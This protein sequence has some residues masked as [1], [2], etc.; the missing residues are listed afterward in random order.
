M[1]RIIA[2]AS[3]VA[4]G[5]ASLH[6]AYAPGLSPQE[7]SKPWSIGLSLRGF[8]DDNP[9]SSPNHPAPG[10]GFSGPEA[11]WG[12]EVSPYVNINM[13]LD[14]TLISFN[15]TYDLRWFENRPSDNNDQY[16]YI[17]LG[18]NHAFS[19][20]YVL[21]VKDSFTVGK[22]P[23]VNF[24]QNGA[25]T[26]LRTEGNYINN[27]ARVGFDAGLSEKFGLNVSYVNNIWDF[28]DTGPSSRS[29]FLDRMEQYPTVEAKY[30]FSPNTVGLIGA[31]FGSVAHTAS[32][33]SNPII[34][35]DASGVFQAYAD[36][37]ARDLW[38][39]YGYVGV[40][41]TFNP[42]LNAAVR[43]GV[44]YASFDNVNDLGYY[45]NYA[46]GFAPNQDDTSTTPYA[47]ASLTWTYNPGCALKVGVMYTRNQ[48]DVASLDQQSAVGYVNLSH[49]LTAKLTASLMG[50]IQNSEYFGGIYDGE[51]DLIYMAGANLNY[52]FNQYLSTDVG[53]NF[54]RDDSDL[55]NRSY[56]RNRFYF[57]LR[58]NY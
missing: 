51:A 29:A 39:L 4:L 43:L 34:I 8:Y 47:D 25:V 1:K 2:S 28:S 10:S 3:M 22:D 58:A 35:S 6:A 57:G 37:D 48:T 44:Q 49:R 32:A 20:R 5:A 21:D 15:Y 11:S 18:I 31:Q 19:E 38:S 13:A 24:D 27:V 30:H 12:I 23:T 42:T 26:F 16:H 53:Y 50:L 41:Q 54:D 33:G 36:P 45:S 7:Q 14:Q 56:S 17:T 55:P 40:E 9:T 52:A 46:P